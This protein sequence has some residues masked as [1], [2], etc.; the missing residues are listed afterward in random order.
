MKINSKTY[1][2][3]LCSNIFKIILKTGVHEA[4]K[5]EIEIET[6]GNLNRSSW[7][8]NS[9]ISNMRIVYRTV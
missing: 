3:K 4:V 9:L 8:L 6:E 2:K 7:L 1:Q 5:I